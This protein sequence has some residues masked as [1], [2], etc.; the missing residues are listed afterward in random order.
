MSHKS[1]ALAAA[2]SLAASATASEAL[3]TS[4]EV[5][6]T[7]LDGDMRDPAEPEP[8]T[9]GT[10]KITVDEVNT[11]ATSDGGSAASVGLA[12]IDPE[13]GRAVVQSISIFNA[14][15][16][17]ATTAELV[18]SG[19]GATEV[20]LAAKIKAAID[21]G[22]LVTGGLVTTALATSN[23]AND[24]VLITTVALGQ[25]VEVSTGSNGLSV[26]ETPGA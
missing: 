5:L 2:A 17:V 23:E 20:G 11:A 12:T 26:V 15:G 21:L 7:M 18:D 16:L 14:A 10:A 13:T 1:L 9:A 3:S 19:G 6:T 25:S 22:P 8:T 4:N 24:A